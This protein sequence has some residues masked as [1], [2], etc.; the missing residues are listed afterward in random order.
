M[1]IHP[2]FENEVLCTV[3][4]SEKELTLCEMELSY[5]VYQWITQTGS[6]LRKYSLY[7]AVC[8]LFTDV[9]NVWVNTLRI[10]VHKK[11]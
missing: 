8:K 3:L 11:I 2:Y 1:A 7:R 9:C 10:S 6:N 5:I 4:L